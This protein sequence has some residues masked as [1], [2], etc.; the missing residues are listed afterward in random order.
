VKFTLVDSSEKNLVLTAQE[1]GEGSF[2]LLDTG[3]DNKAVPDVQAAAWSVTNNN[4]SF[5]G[6]VELP[7]VLYHSTIGTFT[8]SRLK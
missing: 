1:G 7:W 2:Q 3:P 6:E 8:A 5:S 4:L